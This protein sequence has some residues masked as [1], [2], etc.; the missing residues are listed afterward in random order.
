MRSIIL[1]LLVVLTTVFIGWRI[2]KADRFQLF[3]D[4]VTHVDTDQQLV[5]LTFDDGPSRKHGPDVLALLRHKN[6]QATFFINGE[7]G[8]AN[9]DILAAMVAD[10]HELG[11]HA[12]THDRLVLVSPSHVR[13]Q[14]QKTDDAIRRAGQVG[15]IHFRPPYGARLVVLPWVL[16][17]QDRLTVMWN[18]EPESS[19]R[20]YMEDITA[21]AV[22]QAQ[23]GSIIILHPM[24]RSN[25]QTRAALADIIDG[26]RAKGLEPVTLSKLLKAG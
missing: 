25:G 22:E 6:V 20:P 7:H 21:Y 1:I 13:A 23:A 2:S 17:Q 18:V 19:D 5:G 8:D 10:G 15:P 3:G 9:P 16:W 12:Y 11:N 14:L 24:W 26:L 4:V